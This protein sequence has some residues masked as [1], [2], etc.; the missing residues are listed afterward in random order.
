LAENTTY[1]WRVRAD[2]QCTIAWRSGLIWTDTYSFTTTVCNQ[3][4]SA[5]NLLVTEADYC[6]APYP[7]IILSWQFSDPN[8]GD[9]QSAYQVQVDNQS[10]F[11][12]PEVDSGKVNSSHNE[13]AP[14]GLS[15]NT[16]YYWRVRVWDNQDT[17]SAWSV[18]PS[19]TTDLHPYPDPDFSWSPPYPT[20]NELIQFIDQTICYDTDATCN[21][22]FWNFGDGNSTTTQNPTHSYLE[23]GTYTVTLE[24]TD[25][26]GYTCSISKALNVELPLPEWKEIPPF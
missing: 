10:W 25:G 12:S 11:P 23:T 24:V 15:F 18:G 17:V 2:Y 26:T 1:Q 9:T 16:T 5:I 7:P 8:P 14:I 6:G 13:Y 3:P 20:A 19:F 21:L 22:W 4:P